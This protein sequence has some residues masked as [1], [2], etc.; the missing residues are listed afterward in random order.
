MYNAKR[1]YFEMPEDLRTLYLL[2]IYA[3]FDD[4]NKDHLM[5]DDDNT[6]KD[7]EKNYINN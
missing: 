5:F 1:D 3:K 4:A 7:E 2:M 6:I